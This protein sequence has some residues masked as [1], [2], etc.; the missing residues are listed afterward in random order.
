V[1]CDDCL[2]TANKFL[3]SDCK[4]ARCLVQTFA[5]K[6]KDFM[7]SAEARKKAFTAVQT[8]QD[9]AKKAKCDLA[10]GTAAAE[11]FN[12]KFDDLVSLLQDSQDEES[13]DS[14]GQESEVSENE[15]SEDSNGSVAAEDSHG[16][17]L[18]ESK[19]DVSCEQCLAA[20]NKFLGSDCKEP[21][22][23]VQAFAT[24]QKDFMVS[25]DERKKAFTAVQTFHDCATKNKCDIQDGLAAAEE[26]QI[27]IDDFAS[28]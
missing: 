27:N 22:C 26:F 16:L 17:S 20:A 11:E 18:A 2:A 8:F 13:E 24:K 28:L 14:E 21:R 19:D 1:T 10:E 3:G 5:A 6:Q 23:L 15:E 4:D 12:I 25:A 7:V 9:C